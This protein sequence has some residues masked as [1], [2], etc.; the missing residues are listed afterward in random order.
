MATDGGARGNL[1]VVG[2]FIQWINKVPTLSRCLINP[3]DTLNY[4]IYSAPT[5]WAK[6]D[7]ITNSAPATAEHG[8]AGLLAENVLGLWVQTLDPQG[9]PIGQKNSLGQSIGLAGRNFDSRL[10]YSYTN[11]VYT[12]ASTNMPSA[13]PSTV[14]IAILVLDSRTAKRLNG[15]AAEKP[16]AT[17]MTT[18]F[19][20][21]I[22]S[23]IAQLPPAI[24][25]GAELQTVTVDLVNGPR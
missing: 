21:D 25:K 12:V 4:K 11:S 23:F 16:S 10:V 19:W 8:Y 15:I 20:G 2:Y 18:N 7:F 3:S 9:N 5:G 14:Q 6:D 17:S 1:A 24:Q 13:L 22:Q